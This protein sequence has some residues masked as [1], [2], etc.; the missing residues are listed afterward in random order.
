MFQAQSVTYLR[1][2]YL[3][4]IERVIAPPDGTPERLY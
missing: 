4:R 1:K 3:P 2:D